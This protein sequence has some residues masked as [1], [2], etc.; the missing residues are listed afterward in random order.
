MK[1]HSREGQI[2]LGAAVLDDVLGVI[3][4]GLLYEFS[5]GGGINWVNSAKVPV[6]VSAY[7]AQTIEQ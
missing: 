1:S 3:L 6:L 4:L 5:I 7:F 2:V